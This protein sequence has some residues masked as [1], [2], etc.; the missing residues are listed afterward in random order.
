MPIYLLIF[1]IYFLIAGKLFA[2][3]FFFVCLGSNVF[4]HEQIPVAIVRIA[5]VVGQFAI[6]H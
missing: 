4:G 2:I 6:D 3:S 1:F 5:T